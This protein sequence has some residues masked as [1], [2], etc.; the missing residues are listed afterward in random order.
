MYQ[1]KLNILIVE[2]E[3]S[4]ALELEMLLEVAG[5]HLVGRIDNAEA[6]Y[7]AIYV[8]RPDLILMDVDLNGEMT[9]I[10]LG[11]RISPLNIPIIYITSFKDDRVFKAAQQSR[12]VAYLVK[13]ISKYTLQA[14]IATVMKKDFSKKSGETVA[15]AN[16]FTNN[17]LFIKQDGV[18]RKVST[19]QIKYVQSNN[20]HCHIFCD[21]DRP[22]VVRIPI[23][24]V[25]DVL[26]SAG[27]MRIHRQYIIRLDAI[28][29][30]DLRK[31]ILQIGK[32]SIPI[33]RNKKNEL[34]KVMKKIE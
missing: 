23:S 25:E 9:G 22:Y 33:S 30:V 20:N 10:E 12:M 18:Y 6:A 31:N 3:L 16:Y 34:E 11:Q 4:F 28:D 17:Y 7:E 2:D 24:T 26:S 29:T 15:N 19:S 27:F 21:K 14:A 5:H 8:N 1:T 13:P 32:T